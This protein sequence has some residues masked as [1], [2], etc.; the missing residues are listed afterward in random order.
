MEPGDVI[1]VVQ[2]KEHETFTRDGNDL[3]CT[4][5]LGLTEALCGFHF[6][7]KH[8]DERDLVIKYP[9]GQVIEPGK[10]T[11]AYSY[12]HAH[13]HSLSLSHTLAPETYILAQ[14]HFLMSPH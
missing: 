2:Q 11:T 14:A 13:T 6:T 7:L 12:T 4:Y 3:Y 8:L 9:A 1:I 5:N 10:A